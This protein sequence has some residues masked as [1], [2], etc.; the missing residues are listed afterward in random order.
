VG[1]CANEET[2]SREKIPCLATFDPGALF[3]RTKTTKQKANLL[4]FLTPHVIPR[5]V[6]PG[7]IFERKMQSVRV[8]G[9][10]L[11]VQPG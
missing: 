4:L 11:R 2:T 5:P 7:R 8:F 6:R 9:P 3:R 10:L 1:S